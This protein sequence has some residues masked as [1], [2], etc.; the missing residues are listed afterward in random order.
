VTTK[1]KKANLQIRDRIVDFRRV[2][3]RDLIPNPNNWR[4]HSE[5]QRQTL[6]AML[7][8][9]GIADALIARKLPDGRLAVIDGHM[10]QDDHPD[11][12]WPTL[13]LDVTEEEA[14]K[15]LLSLDP[16]AGMATADLANLDI[17]RQFV[18]TD[19]DQ[20]QALWD[21][22]RLAAQQMQE[23]AAD[24]LSPAGDPNK[25]ADKFMVAPFSVLSARDGWWQER[26][27]AWIALGI[28]SELGRGAASPPGGS[29]MPAVSRK[30][31]KIVRS[32]SKAR[33][34]EGRKK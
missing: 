12:E 13:V 31:G 4:L 11:I 34:I 18:H 22:Q 17:L 3:G 29:L 24:A 20:L 25:L 28:Q 27:R 1:K 33:P 15:L 8:E 2:K 14:A 30:T 21:A 26:K 5:D 10:R 23:A 9:I 6:A 7:G 32:D 16:I 19:S